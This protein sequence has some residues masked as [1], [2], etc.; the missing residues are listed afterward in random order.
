MNYNVFK[1][2]VTDLCAKAHVGVRFFKNDGKF[3]AVCSDGTRIEG[4]PGGHSMTVTW[5]NV[6]NRHQRHQAMV[7]V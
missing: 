3:T 6:G 2:K 1:S 7:T 4:I 5:G